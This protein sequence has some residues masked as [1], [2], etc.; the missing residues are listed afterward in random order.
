MSDYQAINLTL[1]KDGQVVPE[2]VV[3]NLPTL[4]KDELLIRVQYSS[5][6]H[7]DALALDAK[8]GVIRNYPIVPGI[9]F[10]G[11]VIESNHPGFFTGDKVVGTGFEFG[12]QRDGGYS[13][14][15][16]A[17][18]HQVFKIPRPLTM[19]DAMILGTAG[20]TAAISLSHFLQLK[21]TVHKDIPLL[22]TGVTGGAGGLIL[23]MLHK[24]DFQNITAVTRRNNITEYLQNLGAQKIIT[25]DELANP[26]QKPL[27]K[28]QYLAVL[29]SV[30]GQLLGDTLSR[31]QYG[32]C[33]ITFGNTAGNQLN[34]S[35]L[36]FILR[37]I[38][39]IG[40]DSVHYPAPDRQELWQLMAT[41]F[42]PDSEHS[43]AV[44]EVSFEDML[45]T[46]QHFNDKPQ[47]GRTIIAF[48]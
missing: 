35:V 46:L 42:R 32:G 14:F 28:Q 16:I 15:V 26:E 10:A 12:V 23:A 17:P 8:S 31:I 38:R 41:A 22:V 43:V 19:R 34:T 13:E 39:L 33:A 25:P 27:Q 18:A 20:L 7:K 6:N 48:P 44:H 24:L 47:L 11:M 37:G 5:I 2:Y 21:E 30:G 36:P 4:K 40:V 3:K 29:D 45:P 1:T 9:D